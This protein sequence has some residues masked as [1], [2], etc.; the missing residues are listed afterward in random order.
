M[1]SSNIGINTIIHNI[2]QNIS[3]KMYS[4]D[5]INNIAN[6]G[7]NYTLP[8]YTLAIIN[9]V[10]QLV[11][12]PSYIKTP[13]F[14][15]KNIDYHNMDNMRIPSN[16]HKYEVN[17]NEN[18]NENN[19]VFHHNK[20]NDVHKK[21]R[22]KKQTKEVTEFEW[23]TIRS[24]ET[25]K[26]VKNEEGIQKEMNA[27]RIL[28]N[29]L[30][31]DNYQ[32]I[33]MEI[34]HKL[35]QLIDEENISK[36]DLYDLGYMI[37][38]IGT[39]NSFYS[40]LYAKLFKTL[41]CKFESMKDVFDKSYNDFIKI[42][43]NI[44]YVSPDDDYDKYCENNQKNE[45]RRAIASFMANLV[46]EEMIK[47]DEIK[48]NIYLFINMFKNDICEKDKSF[49]C[50]EIMEILCNILTNCSKYIKENNNETLREIFNSLYE[51]SEYNVKCYVS[52]TN[53]SLF[54]CMDIVEFL[55][56]L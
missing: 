55:E 45:K 56:E 16:N 39:Q 31:S 12:S 35:Q 6:G 27:L 7:F 32:D 49:I 38:E 1:Y 50:E 33:E 15:R 13:I 30:S 28:L 24:F 5:E 9:K 10:A 3:I 26:V 17:E 44:E 42:F 43:E 18:E 29:K 51:I 54:K 19:K 36:N 2:E 23:Q 46:N 4:I 47:I 20:N 21:R 14:K 25:T 34:T 53:K 11:G 40:N 41:M 37:F 48:K 52:L 8:E 22:S